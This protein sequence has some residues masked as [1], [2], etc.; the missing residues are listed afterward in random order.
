MSTTQIAHIEPRQMAIARPVIS[1]EILLAEAEQRKLLGQYISQQMTEGV[2]YGVI[3]G[4]KNKTLLKPGAEKLTD[5]FRCVPQFT[6]QDKIE[7]WA[8]GLFHYQFKCEIVT[9]DGGFVVAEGFGSCSTRESKYRWRNDER[10][11]PLCGAAAIMKS[12]YPPKSNPEAKPGFYCFGKKGGCGIEFLAD[13]PAIVDQRVGKIENPDVADQINTVLKMAKK[14]AQVDAAIALARCS[15]M[16]TQDAEDFADMNGGGNQSGTPAQNVPNSATVAKNMIDAINRDSFTPGDR[17][18]LWKMME[19]DYKELLNDA[20]RKRVD[21][22][23]NAR[24]LSVDGATKA[25]A[26][27]TEA[28]AKLRDTMIKSINDCETIKAVDDFK[29]MVKRDWFK[30]THADQKAVGEAGAE[31]K[32]QLDADQH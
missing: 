17:D 2:D 8:T 23:W 13:D 30:M 32:R 27:D 12:K 16:F 19:H 26:I 11:C 5:L 7:D 9:R 4:T 31:K 1:A 20:D 29:E 28:S 14:R 15:D 24:K 3:P 25:P 18:G 6:I 22:A 21:D 10:K